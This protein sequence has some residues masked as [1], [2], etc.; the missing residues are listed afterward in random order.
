[1][2]EHRPEVNGNKN[3]VGEETLNKISA[4]SGYIPNTFYKASAVNFSHVNSL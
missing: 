1:M 2:L 4:K 3:G